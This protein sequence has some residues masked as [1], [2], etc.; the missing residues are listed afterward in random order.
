M[1]T[2]VGRTV[3]PFARS[4]ADIC[5]V[6]KARGQKGQVNYKYSTTKN[7]IIEGQATVKKVSG[8]P[9]PGYT[10]I[11]TGTLIMH[12]TRPKAGLRRMR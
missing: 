11:N 12:P 3:V 8:T 6:V 1:F 2:T 4:H 5:I 10:L 9:A 7:Q